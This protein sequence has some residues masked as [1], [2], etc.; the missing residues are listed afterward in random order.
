[1]TYII[2]AFTNDRAHLIVSKTTTTDPI[3]AD[4]AAASYKER[5]FDVVR[6]QEA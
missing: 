4:L 6:Q 2:A 5:G 1:M 3:I